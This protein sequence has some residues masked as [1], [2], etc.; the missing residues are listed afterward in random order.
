MYYI[1][2]TMGL[3][4]VIFR[5]HHQQVDGRGS[6]TTCQGR[7]NLILPG[8]FGNSC[9][10][11]VSHKIIDAN[12]VGPVFQTSSVHCGIF[13][14]IKTSGRPHAARDNINRVRSGNPSCRKGGILG[15][16]RHRV[17]LIMRV[18]RCSELA[19]IRCKNIS[20]TRAAC[21]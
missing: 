2:Q 16:L 21:R 5:R 12:I 17:R 11:N 14:L 6:R 10:V 20:L 4:S 8:R 15:S 7:V 3:V 18:G 13:Y 1:R 9:L 19:M